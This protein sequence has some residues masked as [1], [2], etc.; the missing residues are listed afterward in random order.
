MNDCVSPPVASIVTRCV[1]GRIPA[2]ATA[3][4]I[5]AMAARTAET[6]SVLRIAPPRIE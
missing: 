5:V 2:T 4:A 1:A 6:T 3:V